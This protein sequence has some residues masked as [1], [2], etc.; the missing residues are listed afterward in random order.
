MN[1][2]S[3]DKASENYT[4]HSRVGNNE[5][6]DQQNNS[7]L[8]ENLKL[9]EKIANLENAFL[10]GGITQESKSQFSRND[11]HNNDNEENDNSIVNKFI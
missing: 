3:N 10:T 7:L 5:I 9:K 11:Y 6:L 8:Q 1:S 2:I 4:N